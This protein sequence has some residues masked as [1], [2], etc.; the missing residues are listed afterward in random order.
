MWTF[1]SRVL[2]KGQLAATAF[3]AKFP[4]AVPN[5][6]GPFGPILS[7]H[8]SST[9]TRG[10]C[11]TYS[12]DECAGAGTTRN[13]KV[14]LREMLLPC[15]YDVPPSPLEDLPSKDDLNK[16]PP[17]EFRNGTCIGSR[18]IVIVS[19]KTA[20]VKAVKSIKTELRQAVWQDMENYRFLGFDIESKPRRQKG[21]K[22]TVAMLQLATHST[23]Y[24]FRTRFKG[25]G[26]ESVGK[27]AWTPELRKLLLNPNII[28]IGAGV[29]GDIKSLRDFYGVDCYHQDSFL[30]LEHLV[31][32]KWALPPRRLGLRGLTAFLLRRKLTKGQRMKNWEK[33]NLTTAMKEYAAADAFVSLDLLDTIL[34]PESK[35]SLSENNSKQFK[36]TLTLAISPSKERKKIV[37]SLR[38]RLGQIAKNQGGK[39]KL[40][41]AKEG[42]A[43]ANEN[44]YALTLTIPTPQLEKF[45][46]SVR[47]SLEQVV[48]KQGGKAKLERDDD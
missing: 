23:A 1:I 41:K 34:P 12:T 6:G 18:R 36:Y 17:Y 33:A 27:G 21:E 35:V 25:M 31:R 16:L 7:S 13:K 5:K 20:S 8:R 40:R 26:E 32:T 30:D 3:R 42:K 22:Q 24:L 28:K 14:S 15:I 4:G 19:S 10:L 43:E 11:A 38:S 47:S 37:S 39:V 44:A 46:A 29:D 9:Q 48:K 2:P 45:V